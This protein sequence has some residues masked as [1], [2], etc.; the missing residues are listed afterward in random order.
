MWLLMLPSSEDEEENLICPSSL[1]NILHS[2]HYTKYRLQ[3]L[4]SRMV[5]VQMYHKENFTQLPLKS[6]KHRGCAQPLYKGDFEDP[7][8]KGNFG[9]PFQTPYMGG[10][11]A[12]HSGSLN[13]TPRCFKRLYQAPVHRECHKAHRCFRGLHKVLKKMGALWKT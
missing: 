11:K 5:T 6:G 9:V 13:K 10:C 4:G 2:S 8:Y 12:R 3:E 7:L 1:N